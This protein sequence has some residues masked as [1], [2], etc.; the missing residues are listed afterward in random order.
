MSDARRGL[1]A[2]PEALIEALNAKARRPEPMTLAD[3]LDLMAVLRDPKRGCPWDV[4]QS[5]ATIAP[6]TIEE[7]YE[8]ADAIARGDMADL[9]DELGDLLLQVAYHAQ[10]ADEAGEFDFA[11]VAD[12]VTR[13]MIRRHPHV[14]GDA[15]GHRAELVRG[16]WDRVKADEAEAKRL[17]RGGAEPEP[18]RLLDGVPLALP[19]LTRSVK[20]QGKAAKVGF[21]WAETPLILDKLREEIAEFEAEVEA[22]RRAEMEEEYGDL[23][24]VLANVARHLDIDPEAALARANRKF[25]RRFGHIERRL[26]AD[27]RT[28]ESASLAEMEALWIEA[29]TLEKKGG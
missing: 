15:D 24:F 20:L 4:Q 5:F 14:F 29:K 22:G 3:F 7:A 6:Y 1:P 26:R 17:A 8:V 12:S 28:L 10:M 16:L 2:D 9:R 18:K 11:A 27:G 13:K 25:E 21:D 19:A 23:M